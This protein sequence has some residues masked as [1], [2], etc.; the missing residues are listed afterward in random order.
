LEIV[1]AQRVKAVFTNTGII[2][3]TALIAVAFCELIVR[4]LYA[5]TIVLFPRYHTDAQ[6][7]EFTLRKI[8]SNADFRHKSVDAPGDL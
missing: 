3:L 1:S 2:I 5:D 6:Y 4:V 8:R 7:G